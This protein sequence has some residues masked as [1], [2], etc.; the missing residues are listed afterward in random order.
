MCVRSKGW[1]LSECIHIG[2]FLAFFS[3]F[4]EEAK[5]EFIARPQNATAEKATKTAAKNKFL[6][7]EGNRKKETS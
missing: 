2:L 7:G 5:G 1:L 4:F 3:F 6:R